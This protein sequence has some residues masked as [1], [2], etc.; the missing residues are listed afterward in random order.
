MF[1]IEGPNG[2]GRD[3]CTGDEKGSLP[4]PLGH[5]QGLLWRNIGE[6]NHNPDA[7]RVSLGALEVLFRSRVKP[8]PMQIAQL[9][10]LLWGTNDGE[11]ALQAGVQW[12][13]R[14]NV[15]CFLSP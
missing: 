6:A 11:M 8:T 7:K 4:P 14:K 5:L 15:C 2:R 1:P 13:T 9:L 12:Y 3:K 10:D